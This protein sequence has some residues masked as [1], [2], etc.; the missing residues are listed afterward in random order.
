MVSSFNTIIRKVV[1]IL[2]KNKITK[3]GIFGSYA[4]G[5]QKKNSDVD[6]VV[7]PPKNIGFGFV[8]IQFELEKALGKKVDL[9]TYKSLNRH[10]KKDILHEEVRIL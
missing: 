3:A 9:V 4:R 5:E 2:R 1:P 8:G 10:I 7:T 6:I